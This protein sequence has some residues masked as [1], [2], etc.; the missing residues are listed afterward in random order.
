MDIRASNYLNS[1]AIE[2]ASWSIHHRNHELGEVTQDKKPT[3]TSLLDK[4]TEVLKAYYSISSQPNLFNWSPFLSELIRCLSEHFLLVA[5]VRLGLSCARNKKNSI[6]WRNLRLN[7][8]IKPLC[9]TDFK[10]NMHNR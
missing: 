4:P 5:Q 1:S 6:V 10:C 9:E 8:I 3:K 7:K 2:G